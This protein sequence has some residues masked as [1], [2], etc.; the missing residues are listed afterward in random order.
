LVTLISLLAN[1]V[2]VPIAFFVLAGGLLS[3]IAAPFSS[4][5]SIVF[6]NA[7]WT[8][9]KMILGVVHLFA[10]MP[11]GH[12]Y[13]E[14][15]HWPSGA[16]LEINALDLKSGAALHLRTAN[17]DWLFDAGPAREYDRV[18]RQY[19]RARGINRLDGLVLTQG[20]AAHIGAASGVLLDFHPRE[21]IESTAERRS[22]IQRTLV[23]LLTKEK[24]IRRRC[25]A[26]DE[27]NLS[28]DV[29]A[30]VLF[31][32]AGFAADRTDDQT[33]VI[34]ILVSGKPCAL[35]MSDSGTAT[36]EFL[37]RTYSDLRSDILVKGQHHS[38]ISGSE[39]FL[40]R[41]QPQAIIATS[42]DF[43]DS[44]RIKPEWETSVR[45]RGI[46]LFRQDETGAVQI[47]IFRDHWEATTFVSSE[48]FRS[49]SR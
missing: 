36:E 13:I 43:P 11:G 9:T 48:T 46:K 22:P 12:F 26:G 5:L 30:R 42:R 1:L 2:V 8:L 31:P 45:A 28:R 23:D 10:Q 38:G 6:N 25:Q 3:M 44:E 35:L 39:A 27:F 40:E 34:Q 24:R 41:V 4:W 7:N 29:R 49:T 19:L 33:L 37:L 14:H 17:R 15:P 16:K 20:G 47:K 32:P 21:V 18:L